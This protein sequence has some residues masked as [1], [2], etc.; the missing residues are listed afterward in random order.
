MKKNIIT[1]SRQFGSGGRSVAKQLAE[2]LGIPYYDK[3]IIEMVVEKTGFHPDYV[4]QRGEHAPYASTFAYAFA[5]R[6]TGGM[7]ND[8]LL[9]KAQ[10]HAIEE[11]TQKGP[12]VILGRCADYLL[13]ERQDAFH[14]FVCADSAF[15]A[16][17]VVE[18]YGET[19]VKIEKRLDEKD[20]K[21]RV[22]YNHYTGRKWGDTSNY[23]L[24]INSASVGVDRVADLIIEAIKAA[25]AEA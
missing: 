20:R 5:G 7:S 2:K 13:R 12:C 18:K 6:N 14:V 4:S 25:E 10:C 3:E 24:A 17:R 8:D 1:V 19:P 21:R 15:R 11:L 23:D 16:K 9:W 22:S